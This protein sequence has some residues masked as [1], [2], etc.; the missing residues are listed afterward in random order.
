VERQGPYEDPGTL[1]GSFFI[2]AELLAASSVLY[3]SFCVC[4][5]SSGG[6]TDGQEWVLLEPAA[7]VVRFCELC[8][9]WSDG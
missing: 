2:A 7:N 8:G 9:G 3:L 5:C 4:G 1:D 6:C